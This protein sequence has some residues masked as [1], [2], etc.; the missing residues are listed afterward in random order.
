MVS[1]ILFHPVVPGGSIDGIVNVPSRQIGN[2]DLLGVGDDIVAATLV[3][4]KS[5]GLVLRAT[6][7]LEVACLCRPAK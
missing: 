5:A 4:L 6:L 2:P 1:N 3:L 7:T